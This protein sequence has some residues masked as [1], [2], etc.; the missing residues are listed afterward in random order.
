MPIV[1]Q[2]IISSDRSD[3]V[4]TNRISVICRKIK[5]D[6]SVWNTTY[7]TRSEIT[8]T[9]FRNS[10]CRRGSARRCPHD[11]IDPLGGYTAAPRTHSVT[12]DF[13]GRGEDSSDTPHVNAIIYKSSPAE[14]AAHARP[15]SALRARRGSARR[16]R[17]GAQE[18]RAFAKARPR[19]TQFRSHFEKL[20]YAVS[21]HTV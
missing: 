15:P 1:S 18:A 14:A 9:I 8:S 5:P 17:S 12:Q 6:Y 2:S 7:V 19:A 13:R 4:P 16:A 3:A 20:G 10:G 21:L 11:P